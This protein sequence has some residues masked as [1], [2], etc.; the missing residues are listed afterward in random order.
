VGELVVDGVTNIEDVAELT[1]L[2]LPEGPYETLA[3][4]IMAQVGKLP[5]A[6]Q[7]IEVQGYRLTVLEVENRRAT[8][9][10]IE[11]LP[12]PQHTPS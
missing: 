10:K 2:E 3:G 6:Q 5:E 8:K 7:S 4:F 11:R 1:D 9:V 12:E